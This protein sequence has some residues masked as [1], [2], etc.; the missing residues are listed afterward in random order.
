MDRNILLKTGITISILIVGA[1][2]AV[3]IVLFPVYASYDMENLSRPVGVL[4]N[5]VK[6]H[7]GPNPYAVHASISALAVFVLAALIL[8]MY[9]FEK[10]QSP[11]IPF[12]VLFILSL[13]FESVRLIIP[14]QQV[15]TI[16]SIYIVLATRIL[17]ISREFGL[18]SLFAASIYAVGFES[19]R[20][21][22]I[23]IV[24]SIL[25][26]IISLGTPIDAFAYMTNFKPMSGYTSLFSILN[27]GLFLLTFTGFLVAAHSQRS[28][29]YIFVS[30]GIFLTFTGRNM[31]LTADTWVGIPGIALLTVGTWLMCFHLHKIYLWL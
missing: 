6:N 2:I 5:L 28:R 15:L 12:I 7:I 23:I 16:P 31:L 10:T 27:A 24:I 20:Q 22:N 1:I 18:F 26:L 19:Q 21:R 8:I 25:A 30:I 11:E 17:I 29:N 14:L 9:R 3:S 13:A 4:Q